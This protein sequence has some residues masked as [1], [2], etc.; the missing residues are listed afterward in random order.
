MKALKQSGCSCVFMLLC[1]NDHTM[2]IMELLEWG[3]S[4]LKRHHDIDAF[5]GEQ[6]DS[7]IL[8]SEIL[9]A[10]ALKQPKHY[11]FAHLNDTVPI[12]KS[13]KFHDFIR[14]RLKHEP[15]A[16]IIGRKAFYG[17]DFF[18]NQYVLVPRPETETLVESA[19]EI[20]KKTKGETWF[21]DI[22]V[23]SGT[24]AVTLAAETKLPVIAT[25]IS[26]RVITIAK[27]N[28]ETHEVS[29]LIDFK[30]GDTF[31]PVAKLFQKVE[32]QKS[33]PDNL[34]I[35]ANLP[36]LKTRQWEEAQKEVSQWEPKE[37]LEA[38]PDGLNDYW[39]LFRQLQQAQDRLPKSVHVLIEI[40]PSQIDSIQELI[41][42]YF[43]HVELKTKKDLSGLDR[44]VIAKIK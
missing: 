7:P 4:K 23:G 36:Y 3:N 32:V 43:P 20:S 1:F 29:D 12:D 44:V 35:C 31:E 42:H 41:K 25:D 2:I 30:K 16:Y 11:L 8:D 15:V 5:T 22:G 19:I 10:H 39:T 24:I 37:A 9:L 26:T 28:A 33:C 27:K 13:D 18:V 21:V 34:I 6:L 38:G 14:R 40:D 17:R